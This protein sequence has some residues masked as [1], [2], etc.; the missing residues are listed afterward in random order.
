MM[1]MKVSVKNAAGVVK[2]ESVNALS[3]AL[4][5]SG[6]V[7]MEKDFFLTVDGKKV[8]ADQLRFTK[9]GKDGNCYT[10]FT[11]SEKT[12]YLPK[13]CGHLVK[14]DVITILAD[15]K[16]A[17]A[18]AAPKVDAK[19]V[20]ADAAAKA[21]ALEAAKAGPTKGRARRGAKAA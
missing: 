1:K 6:N 13:D 16:A 5:S 19:K 2:F 10:Y 3:Y 9:G 11:Y 12:Y 17:A 14:G 15:T 7:A 20:E 4:P 8:E 21:K 18:P